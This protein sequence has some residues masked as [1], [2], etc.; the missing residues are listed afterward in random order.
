MEVNAAFL[1]AVYER[2][3][4]H[5]VRISE[6]SGEKI[7]VGLY[8][9]PAHRQTEARIDERDDLVLLRLGYTP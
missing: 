9:S 5:P 6:F 3:K 1:M 4:I 7:V 8:N 2:V